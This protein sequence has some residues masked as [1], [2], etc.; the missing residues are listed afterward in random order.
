MRVSPATGMRVVL[1][2]RSVLREP[3]MV[4]FGS[5]MAMIKEAHE[6]LYS[7]KVLNRP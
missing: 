6:F 1:V 2:I 4:M 3:M 7:S 5:T